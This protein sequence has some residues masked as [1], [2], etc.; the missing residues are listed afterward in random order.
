MDIPCN[1]RSPASDK[2]MLKAVYD[3]HVYLYY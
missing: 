3:F 1:M 2:L